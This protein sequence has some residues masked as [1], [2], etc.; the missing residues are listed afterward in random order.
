[1]RISL[2]VDAPQPGHVG[3]A[4]NAVTVHPSQW[5]A[6]RRGSS[7]GHVKSPSA[8]GTCANA[9]PSSRSVGP[10]H[11]VPGAA[12]L[13]ELRVEPLV[14]AVPAQPASRLRRRPVDPTGKRGSPRAW[15]LDPRRL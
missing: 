2:T 13:D 7:D 9:A 3:S 12:A 5:E 10:E 11:E 14:P 4:G 8:I 6:M 15:T 1:R